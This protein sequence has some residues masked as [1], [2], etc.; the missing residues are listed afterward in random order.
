MENIVLDETK[1]YARTVSSIVFVRI[2]MRLL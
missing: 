1:V 2:I